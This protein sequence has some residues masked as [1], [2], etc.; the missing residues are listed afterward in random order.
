MHISQASQM[1]CSA[2]KKSMTNR[3]AKNICVLPVVV[4]E[5][6]FRDVERHVFFADLVERAHHA[7]RE[8]RPEA[9]NRVGVDR[10]DNIFMRGMIDDFVLREDFVEVLITDPMV[11][12]QKTDLVRDGLTHEAGK[13]RGADVFYY[14]GDD[15]ALTADRASND[16]FARS[17]AGSTSL[18]TAVSASARVSLFV[19]ARS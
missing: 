4:A 10:A 15:V 11:G 7:A 6:K 5:L 1:F 2:G 13:G 8:D 9:L 3:V 14:A 17:Y 16:R 19:P 12:N 18:E